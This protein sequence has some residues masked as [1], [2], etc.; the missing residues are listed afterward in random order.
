MVGSNPKLILKSSPALDSAAQW[1]SCW[2]AVEIRWCRL[3]IRSVFSQNDT[4][5]INPGHTIPRE[6][7]PGELQC[8]RS[9]DGSY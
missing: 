4:L 1:M 5:E 8:P 3:G 9:V 7:H 6:S 2:C